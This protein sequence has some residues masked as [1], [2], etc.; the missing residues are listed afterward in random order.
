MESP[1]NP[2]QLSSCQTNGLVAFIDFMESDRE[3]FILS[4][5]PGCGKTFLT[6]IIIEKM[7]ELYPYMRVICSATTNKAANVLEDT[8]HTAADTIHKVL[9]LRVRNDFTTGRQF[10]SRSP[11]S[12]IVHK[13][14]IILDE[15]SMADSQLLRLIGE[16][17]HK[18]KFL[19][20]GDQ[21]QLAPVNEAKS[22]VFN[23]GYGGYELETIMRQKPGSGI[24]PLSRQLR[25]I[26]RTGEF[27]PLRCN[28]SDVIHVDGDTFQQLIN[29]EYVEYPELNHA[30]IICWRNDT[31][32]AYNDYIRKRHTASDH[33]E[34]YE[35]VSTNNPVISEGT[36]H[37]ATDSILEVTGIR[38]ATERGIEGYWYRLNKR[39]EVFQ[40]SNQSEV[41]SHLAMLANMA[42][43]GDSSWHKYF[44]DK[45]FFADLRAVHAC[46]A[47][48]SQGSTYGTSFID[49]TDI[50]QCHQWQAVARML[51]VAI[52]R[53]R[54]KVVLYGNLPQRYIDGKFP[55]EK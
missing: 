24:I 3:H 30:K 31:V 5:G 23:L 21:D 4:S 1:N 13:A 25:T 49:L 34:E 26:I 19:F 46:T 37:F 50:G 51:Y 53:A 7:R 32:N 15:S 39:V 28:G 52:T 36:T 8:I 38:A 10:L 27:T 55:L 20:V 44:A 14:L 18:C 11:D 48:K 43:S 2:V 16:C 33:F 9:G 6:A 41:K 45:E 12:D 35:L 54:H 40:A 17:T 47:Y 42:K 22:P 29:E